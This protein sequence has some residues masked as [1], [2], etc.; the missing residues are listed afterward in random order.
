MKHN[1]EVC[2]AE[3]ITLEEYQTIRC[4][5][6]LTLEIFAERTAH[7]RR[8]PYHRTLLSNEKAGQEKKP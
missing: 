8:T 2:G 7:L 3:L 1:C 4:R 6:H 5:K